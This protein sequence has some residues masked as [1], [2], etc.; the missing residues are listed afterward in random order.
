VLTEKYIDTSWDFRSADT[1]RFTHCFHSYP[2]MMIPQVTA[3]MIEKYGSDSKLIFDP[4]CGTGTSL[5]EA[6]LHGMDAIGTDLNPLAVLIAKTKTTALDLQTLE[7]YLKDFNEKVFQWRFSNSIGCSQNV[8]T[9][10]NIDFWFN[11]S[12]KHKLTRIKDYIDAINNADIRDFFLVAF[13]ETVRE[14]SLTRNSEFKLYRMSDVQ[15]DKFDPDPYTMIENKLFR[16]HAGLVEFINAE[17]NQ[18]QSYVYSF[19]TVNSI[20]ADILSKNSVDIIVTSPPYGDSRT[21]VAYGQFSR[22]SSQWIGYEDA[23][24]LDEEL[25]GGKRSSLYVNIQKFDI[26]IL[27]KTVEEIMNVD[28]KRA[29]DVYRFYKDYALSIGNVASIVKD[30]GYCCYVVGNRRVC[31]T[32]LQTDEITKALFETHGFEHVETIIRNIPNK[33]MPSRNSPSNVVGVSDS[34]MKNEYI[35]VMRKTGDCH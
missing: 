34:T 16:N 7:L 4:Y 32:T 14:S 30:D 23:S 17:R 19:N 25:M 9:F 1:K 15:I 24:L 28:S 5:V 3:R 22:L 26:G 29:V 21:T 11:P 31:G 8:P 35:V 12:T 20:P 18:A 27:D 13:S 6:N 10:N 2:A 33:R